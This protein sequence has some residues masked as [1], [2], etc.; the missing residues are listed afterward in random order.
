MTAPQQISKAGAAEWFA[1]YTVA[2]HEKHVAQV[3][4]QRGV[5]IFL[6]LYQSSR[7]WSKRRPVELHLPLF[8][9]YVF[10]RIE[11]SSRGLVLGVP[12]VLAIVGTP[13]GPWPLPELEIEAMQQGLHLRRAEPREY[14][15]VGARV[16]IKSGPLTGMEG[17]LEREA[18]GVRMVL[19]LDRILRSI[20]VEVS[21]DELEAVGEALPIPPAPSSRMCPMGK[22]Q[23]PHIPAGA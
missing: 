13:A 18:N 20:S 21:L 19:S 7:R 8:P 14:L 16:R 5:E 10:V 6:P 15:A 4:Q 3:L 23:E 9:T 17:V 11:R 2:R 1:V 12:G 22:G